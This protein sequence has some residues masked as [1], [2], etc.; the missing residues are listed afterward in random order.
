MTATEAAI[1]RLRWVG[2]AEAISSLILFCVA[3]P[4]K[5]AYGLKVA[6]TIAGAVHG[7]LFLLLL[8]AL[9]L[10]ARGA[11]WPPLRVGRL[12]F[13]AIFPG[14]P[15][16]CEEWLRKEQEAARCRERPDV[17]GGVG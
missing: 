16:F 4:L 2:F 15:F 10:A 3:M 1:F 9:T 12:V 6:V 14:G 8:L 5:Y 17:G 11:H 7:V 13:A